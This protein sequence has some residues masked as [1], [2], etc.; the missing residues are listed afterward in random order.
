MVAPD[1]E[2]LDVAD[3]FARFRRELRQR[4]IV[5]EPQHRREI[6]RRQRRGGLHRDVR[7]RVGGVADDEHMDGARRH[8]VDRLALL[9]E[10]LGVLHQK[11]FAFHPRA[12]GPCADEHRDV[13]VLE[14]DLRVGRA[15][16]AGEQREGAILEFHHHAAQCRLRLVDGELQ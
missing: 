15:G 2:L 6:L 10:D 9:D 11:V 3:R 4:A 16:H 1:D 8:R 13:G 7:V 14:R 12:A 5:V